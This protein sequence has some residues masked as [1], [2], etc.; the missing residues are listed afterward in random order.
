MAG[1]L[2]LYHRYQEFV[3]IVGLFL[4]QTNVID[5]EIVDLVLCELI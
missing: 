4:K 5:V 2:I 3:S 1:D